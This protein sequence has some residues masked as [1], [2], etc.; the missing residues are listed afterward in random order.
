M[1]QAGRGG[2]RGSG[3]GAGV[4]GTINVRWLFWPY[5]AIVFTATHW[6]KLKIPDPVPRTDLWIHLSCFCLWTVLAGL[7]AFFGPRW[8]KQN[9]GL[10]CFV[11]L[12]YA[13]IDEGLQ[14]PAF[15]G[16]TVALDD[17]GANAIGVIVGTALL[18]LRGKLRG[19]QSA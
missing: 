19:W 18:L 5:A 7:C 9:V 8:S 3:Q 11:A 10:T 13:A 14:F 1:M 6:P 15:L 12:T 16:R 17:L 2:G 4:L